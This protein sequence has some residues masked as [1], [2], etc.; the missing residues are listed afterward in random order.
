MLRDDAAKEGYRFLSLSIYGSVSSPVYAAVMIKRP[1]VVA[2]RDWPLLTADEFQSVFTAQ[3]KKGYGPVMIAAAGTA[4][5]PRF[6][7]VFEPQTPI[8]LTRHRLKSGADSDLETIQGMNRKAKIDGLIL[9]WAAMYGD[10]SNPRWAAI[11]GPNM[12]RVTWNADGVLETGDEYQARFDAHTAGWCRPSF[13]TCQKDGRYLSLFV[14][15]E[16]GPWV[17]AHGL[18]PDE[19]QAQWNDLRPKGYF[20]VCVQAA[21]TSKTAARFAT[22]FVKRESLTVREWNATGPRTNAAID[23]VVKEIM[24]ATPVRHASLAIVKGKKLVY[25]RGYT[26]AEPDWTVVQP[27]S[28]FRIASVSKSLTALAIYQL[29]EEDKLALDDKVQTILGLKTPSGGSPKDS[30]F[31]DVKIQHLLE[32]TSGVNANGYRDDIAVQSAHKTAK[33]NQT[34]NLPV[35]AAMTDSYIASLDMVSDPAKTQV[36]NNCGYYLLGRVL[37]KKRGKSKPIDAL[38]QFLFDPLGVTRIERAR[39]LIKDQEPTEARYR[40]SVVGADGEARLNIAIAKSVMTNARPLVPV[41]YGH[42]Q[43]EKQEGSGGLTAAA[44]DLARIV[45]I[46]LST[47]D[48]PALKR[49]T[50]TSMMMNAVTAGSTFGQRAGHGWDGAASVGGGKYY[51][52]K[53][54]SLDTSGNVLQFNADWGFAMCWAGKLI[55][56]YKGKGWYPDFTAVMDIAKA[57]RWPAADL[58]PQYGMPSL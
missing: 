50:I 57:T 31:K 43:Y 17:A 22:I 38:Q 29:I 28:R 12:G 33:P 47:S 3:A 54:G 55:A 2:Q 7:A 19:Y 48:N 15:N 44:T 5:N 8:P 52:Q 37:A 26:W 21:G 49:S 1:Q 30:R 45:A 32:H 4:S 42:E 13:V 24:K 23:D 10:T 34:W 14:D 46:M 35:T 56:P 39:S 11:W 20:P 53:G 41:G 16:V 25:T 9:R 36:Y 6:A 51:G 58:F 27:T 18:S 40:M